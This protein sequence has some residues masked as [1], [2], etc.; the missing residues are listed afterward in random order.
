MQKLLLLMFCC[1]LL[2]CKN[3]TTFIYLDE[4]KG[5]RLW[6]IN[7]KGIYIYVYSECVLIN[8]PPGNKDSLKKIMFAY[9]DSVGSNIDTLN[10]RYGVYNMNFYEKTSSTSKYLHSKREYY[11]S[12]RSNLSSES[13]NFLGGILSERCNNDSTKWLSKIYL[14]L[15]A[16]EYG[17]LE[18]KTDT[19]K[20]ECKG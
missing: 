14:V 11:L 2:S 18:S 16:D 13:E 6:K 10:K 8:N 5:E 1:V 17:V 9:R 20:N 12:T 15:K 3:K 19:L 4:L 7:E